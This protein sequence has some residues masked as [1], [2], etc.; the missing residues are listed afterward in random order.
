MSLL[1]RQFKLFIE[2]GKTE[3]FHFSKLQEVFNPPSLDLSIL[4]EPVLYSKKN[5]QYL[6]FIFDR[7]LSFHQ[8]INFYTNKAISIVKSIKILG[9]LSRGLILSQK[10][11]LY[12]VCIFP[13]MLYSFPLWFYNKA[14]LAYLLKVL[15]NI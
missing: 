11:L 13:I 15:R 10:H 8:H 14:P 12:R 5:W 4:E 2:H 3:V 6:G 7:K 1:L 9:N